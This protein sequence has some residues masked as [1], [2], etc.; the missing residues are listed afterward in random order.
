MSSHLSDEKELFSYLYKFEHLHNIQT[1]TSIQLEAYQHGLLVVETKGVFRVDGFVQAA[2]PNSTYFIQANLNHGKVVRFDKGLKGYFLLFSSLID[3]GQGLH[4]AISLKLPAILNSHPTHSFKNIARE[5]LDN[6]QQ[7]QMKANLLFQNWMHTLLSDLTTKSS[8]TVK[9]LIQKSRDYI[10]D[11]YHTDLT[12]E[13]LAQLT[14]LNTDYYSRTFK[15]FY[16]KT[17]IE[18][19][20]EVRLLH[21]K[22]KLLQSKDSIRT[23]AKSVGFNDEF[24]FSRKFKAKEGVSPSIYINKLRNSTRFVSLNH[25]VTGHALAL[26]IEPYAAISHAAFPLSETLVHAIS[27]GNHQ[28]SIDKLLATSPD[29]IVRCSTQNQELNSREKLYYNIAP[30]VSLSFQ[31]SWQNHL[32]TIARL[33]NKEAEAKLFLEEYDTRVESIKKSLKQTMDRK[34]LL[35]IGLGGDSLCIY[36]KRNLGTVLYHDLEIAFPPGV[37]NIQHVKKTS[38]EEISRINPD[39]ILLT[40]YR[41]HNQLPTRQA[42][43][44]QLHDLEQNPHWNSLRAVQSQQIYSII[45][46]NHLYTSYNSLSNKLFLEKVNQMLVASS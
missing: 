42:L 17:P 2:N 10:N 31:D 9:Q 22:Q 27:I 23:V 21:A 24:Y 20:N 15:T 13:Q 5:I 8:L 35:V 1:E 4:K 39:Y 40:I 11:H 36:G 12:R 14:G 34:N 30:T 18:Y 26:G 25:L 41:S 29:L 3:Q 32:H 46:S 44:K 43:H 45:N 28:P 7:D 37:E 33:V 38:L 6:Q 16:H 19:L